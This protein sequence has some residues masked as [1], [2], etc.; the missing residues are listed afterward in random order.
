[1]RSDIKL[2]MNGIHKDEEE[3]TE[4]LAIFPE[5]IAYFTFVNKRQNKL[6]ANN[7]SFVF[8]L[9][10]FMPNSDIQYGSSPGPHYYLIET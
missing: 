2:F 6:V 9:H 1:M 5:N 4:K 7:L 3:L 8:P 10:T